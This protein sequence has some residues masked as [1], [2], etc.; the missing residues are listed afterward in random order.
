MG[1]SL[2]SK[3][4]VVGIIFLFIGIGIAPSISANNPLF[5]NKIQLKPEKETVEFTI[6]ACG[7]NGGKQIVELTKEEAE[8]VKHLFNSIRKK[9]SETETRQEAEKVFK[10]AVIELNNYG[11]LEG[12]N[13]NRVQKLVNGKY[14]DTK[15]TKILGRIISGN[16]NINNSN[17]FCLTAGHATNSFIIGPSNILSLVGFF[18]PDPFDFLSF[19]LF[20]FPLSLFG[21][22]IFGDY[23][24]GQHAVYYPAEGWIR[25][26]GLNGLNKLDGKFYGHIK[27]LDLGMGGVFLGGIGFTGLRINYGFFNTLFL[28]SSLMIKIGPK[29][30]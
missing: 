21:L 9:L 1:D 22:M 26:I 17:F 24:I 16:Q 5:E 2:F 3:G 30:I 25:T 6:E 8:E 4:L 28:G 12:L 20:F 11:L 27:R 7:L 23:S 15:I 29:R 10:E 18:L 13:V 19:I 14:Q